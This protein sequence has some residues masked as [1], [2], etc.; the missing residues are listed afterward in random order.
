MSFSGEHNLRRHARLPYDPV[1]IQL[2]RADDGAS[3]HLVSTRDLSAGGIGFNFT[4]AVPVGTRVEVTLVRFDGVDVK[5]DGTVV[6]CSLAQDGWY[7]VGVQFERLIN[8]Q[9]YVRPLAQD[10]QALL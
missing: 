4:S 2:H 7:A 10:C 8:P 5:H 6:H 1:A 3:L 9:D